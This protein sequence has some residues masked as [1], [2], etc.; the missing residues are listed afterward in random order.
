MILEARQGVPTVRVLLIA[1]VGLVLLVLPFWRGCPRREAHRAA[2][3]PRRAAYL[4]DPSLTPGATFRGVSASDVCVP[5][6]AGSVRHVT[7]ATKR[8]ICRRDGVPYPAKGYEI[9]HLIPLALAGS[10]DPEN[11]W[12]QPGTGQWTYHHKDQLEVRLHAMVC[13]G[14][15]TLHEARDLIRTDWPAAYRKYV[16]PQPARIMM[17]APENP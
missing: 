2:R 9:D 6:Y 17:P 7:E 1:L 10:N 15:L 12:A 3:A 11:L 8:D 14:E 16:Q 13:R 4:P 5:G